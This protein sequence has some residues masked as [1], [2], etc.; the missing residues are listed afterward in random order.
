MDE[1][2]WTRTAVVEPLHQLEH[3]RAVGRGRRR[4][5]RL[6][7]LAE[8]LVQGDDRRRARGRDRRA[9]EQRVR[10]RVDRRRL[11]RVGWLADEGRQVKLEIG[12]SGPVV[13]KS[14]GDDG[15]ARR[16]D[17]TRLRE[18]RA[19]F[20]S[21]APLRIVDP[22]RRRSRDSTRILGLTRHGTRRAAERC[23]GKEGGH[24]SDDPPA[25]PANPNDHGDS[26]AGSACLRGHHLTS[27]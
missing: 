3:V 2:H 1:Q 25:R 9:L 23:T 8:E 4:P 22:D 6:R 20:R 13:A 27:T 12:R 19:H 26:P 17:D 5:R 15:A 16:D 18:Q 10:G 24:G 21:N 7:R 11:V 14:L